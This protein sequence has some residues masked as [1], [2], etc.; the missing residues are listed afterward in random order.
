MAATATRYHAGS[1]V[2]MPPYSAPRVTPSS[3]DL[4]SIAS[5]RSMS[6][7]HLRTPVHRRERLLVEAIEPLLQAQ[8]LGQRGQVAGADDAYQQGPRAGPDLQA[9]A[10]GP[11]CAAGAE[12][13]PFRERLPEHANLDRADACHVTHAGPPPMRVSSCSAPCQST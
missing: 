4:P 3:P 10:G 13:A 2:P 8:P 9:A 5:A 12:D 1:R 11:P 6:G 7:A